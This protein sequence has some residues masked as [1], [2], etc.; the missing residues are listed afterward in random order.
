MTLRSCFPFLRKAVLPP[1][2][3]YSEYSKQRSGCILR[4]LFAE[5]LCPDA[6]LKTR[7]KYH[8][9][10]N[11][12]DSSLTLNWHQIPLTPQRPGPPLPPRRSPQ[13]LSPH[14]S[15]GAT[16][17]TG[18]S[19]IVPRSCHLLASLLRAVLGQGSL[20]VGPPAVACPFS[21]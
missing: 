18:L 9:N 12:R 1:C 13:C 11:I 7:H 8:E 5:T 17:R 14:L 19:P 21:L 4:D 10:H 20:A 3:V 6:A 2:N 15:P 16:P